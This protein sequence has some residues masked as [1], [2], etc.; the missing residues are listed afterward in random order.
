MQKN[1]PDFP[2]AR[3]TRDLGVLGDPER[4]G[5]SATCRIVFPG[6][7]LESFSPQILRVQCA[8]LI[9]RSW[10][11]ICH[12][13]ITGLVQT[14]TITRC[15]LELAIGVGQASQR[16]VYDLTVA[17][18][19]V[20]PTGQPAMPPAAFENVVVPGGYSL[21]TVLMQWPLPAVALA[22]RFVLAVDPGIVVG[23][24]TV[25]GYCFAAVSPRA[26]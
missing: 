7:S 16:V 21:G 22:A 18:N 25:Q 17:L 12:W 15:G 26:L 3:N 11:L 1:A 8:D 23:P 14:D 13:N 20:Y 24:H 6:N 19:G 10:E 9:A 2:R 5:G 4:W